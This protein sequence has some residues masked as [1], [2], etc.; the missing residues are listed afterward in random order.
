MSENKKFKGLFITF[1]MIVLGLALA[2]SVATFATSAEYQE[3]TQEIAYGSPIDPAV[4]NTTTT[5]YTIYNVSTTYRA[6]LKQASD[7]VS[8]VLVSET[9]FTC[10]AAKTFTYAE[11][12]NTETY[13]GTIYYDTIDLT[14]SAV[15]ALVPLAPLLYVVTVIAIGMVAIKVQL[16]NRD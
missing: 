2:P 9:N 8:I 16:G 15:L 3:V 1:L 14:S 6:E 4:A 11:L 13:W 7:N 10:T 5:L 12:D